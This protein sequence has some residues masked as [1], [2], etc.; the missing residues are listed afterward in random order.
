MNKNLK[1]ILI[2]AAFIVPVAVLVFLL[3]NSSEETK[4]KY[5][6]GKYISALLK[7]VEEDIGML[8]GIKDE[9]D[10]GRIKTSK[11]PGLASSTEMNALSKIA[12]DKKYRFRF[13][14]QNYQ[15]YVLYRNLLSQYDPQT[16][17][18]RRNLEDG[19][20]VVDTNDMQL[21]EILKSLIIFLEDALRHNNNFDF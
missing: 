8:D 19:Q 14:G 9:I 11:I 2:T 7:S 15:K 5:V 21:I 16:K 10:S 6:R 13:N 3:F 20:Y 4:M 18:S 12:F 17:D 1:T